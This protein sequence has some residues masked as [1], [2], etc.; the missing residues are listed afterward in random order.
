MLSQGFLQGVSFALQL[1]GRVYV[2]VCMCLNACVCECAH[3]C[4]LFD[5]CGP[6]LPVRSQRG[7]L[8]ILCVVASRSHQEEPELRS[9]KS[10]AVCWSH[11]H[12]QG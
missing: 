12:I 6:E 5:S 3:V 8:C 10:H 2:L 11:L 9:R 1:T 7:G 4:V